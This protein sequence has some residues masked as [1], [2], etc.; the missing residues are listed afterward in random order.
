MLEFDICCIFT[1]FEIYTHN[2][3]FTNRH[4]IKHTQTKKTKTKPTN[5]TQASHRNIGTKSS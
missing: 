2:C 4:I 1:I 3:K 5:Q